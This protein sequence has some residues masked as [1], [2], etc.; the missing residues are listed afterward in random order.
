MKRLLF[1]SLL[2]LALLL[3]AACARQVPKEWVPIDGSRMDGNVI[4]ALSW[5]P[6]TE[7]P[8]HELAQ[9]DRVAAERCRRWGYEDAERFGG[10]DENCVQYGSFMEDF[11]CVKMRATM[12]YQCTG[13]PG[14]NVSGQSPEII[15]VAPAGQTVHR[16]K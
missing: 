14:T 12:K 5:N 1:G 3:T 16:V 7:K 10:V 4:V 8:I 11:G 13:A 2:T 6:Q 15:I 9:A